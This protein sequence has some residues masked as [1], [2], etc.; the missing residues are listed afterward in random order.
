M[1]T[2]YFE[3]YYD[4]NPLEAYRNKDGI[5]QFT[6]TGDPLFDQWNKDVAEGKEPD[7]WS[8]FSPDSKEKIIKRLEAYKQAGIHRMFDGR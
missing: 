4:A 3:D 6:D 7:L 2:E 5:V 1:L 8:A